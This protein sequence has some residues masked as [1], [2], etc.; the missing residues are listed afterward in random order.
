MVEFI[1]N[2]FGQ[3]A[4]GGENARAQRKIKSGF[5]SSGMPYIDLEDRDTAMIFKEKLKAFEGIKT[6]K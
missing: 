2:I 3:D 1:K 5:D 6:K 4:C